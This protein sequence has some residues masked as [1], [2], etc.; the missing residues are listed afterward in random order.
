[1]EREFF[2]A[3]CDN[4]TH[5]PRFITT[6]LVTRIPFIN[7]LHRSLLFVK[8]TDQMQL[9]GLSSKKIQTDDEEKNPTFSHFVS[10]RSLQI[11]LKC[12]LIN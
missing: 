11:R 5:L 10:H 7:L 12:C 4:Q 1:M 2:L 8:Y 6:G 9:E 3:R